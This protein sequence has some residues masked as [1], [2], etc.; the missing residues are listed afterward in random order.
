MAIRNAPDNYMGYANLC[1]AYNDLGRYRDAIATCNKSL[2]IKPGDGETYYYMGRAY[3]SLKQTSNA[4]AAFQKALTGLLVF[5]KE[6]PDDA[7][8][9]YLLGNAY[10]E[11]KQPEQAIWSYLKAIELKPNF[12]QARYNLGVTC[13]LAGRKQEALDQYAQLKTIDPK[14]AARLLQIINSR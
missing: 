14:R 13:H 12:A 11:T 4:A 5:V 6:R 7:D 3:S 9:H 1:R 2:T 8:S 10:N